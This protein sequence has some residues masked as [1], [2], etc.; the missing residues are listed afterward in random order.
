MEYSRIVSASGS[1]FVIPRI[2]KVKTRR[3]N[4]KLGLA[5]LALAMGGLIGPL[6]LTARLEAGQVL[7]NIGNTRGAIVRKLNPP[8]PLPPAV[9]I[10][11]NPLLTPD[12]S[13]ISPVN[14]DFSLIVPSI[15]INAPVIASVNPAK[16][17]EYQEALK[18]GVAHASTSY[19]P[20]QNGTVYLF[21]HSTNYEWFVRDLNAVFYHIK[22]LE[23]GSLIVVFYKDNRYTY[24]LREKRVVGP[25]EVSYL[26]PQSGHR[27]LILQTCWPPGSVA[28][29][30]LLFAD[31]IEEQARPI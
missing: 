28:Q 10:V 11:F 19:L 13:A 18:E 12:G 2:E 21:S 15:G 17:G 3:L 20:D 8:K 7:R 27:N 5:L 4:R 1:Y 24:K 29:R 9:P 31:L 26:Q 23:E 25:K 14:T 22:N 30:L 16:T 6:S